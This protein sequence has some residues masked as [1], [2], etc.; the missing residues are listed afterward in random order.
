[1]HR[2]GMAMGKVPCRNSLGTTTA[3]QQIAHNNGKY[4]AISLKCDEMQGSFVLLHAGKR[5]VMLLYSWVSP[6]LA[7]R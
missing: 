7:E 3:I 4:I 1:M 2:S 5:N 6:T